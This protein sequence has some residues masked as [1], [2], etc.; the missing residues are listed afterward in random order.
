MDV[1]SDDDIKLEYTM[2]D[3]DRMIEEADQDER[4]GKLIPYD[5]SYKEEMRKLEEEWKD[6]EYV[7]RWHLL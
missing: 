6:K 2:E 7:D 1:D 5:E 3:L 4:E